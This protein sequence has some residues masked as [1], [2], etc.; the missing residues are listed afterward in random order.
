[1]VPALVAL[2]L[3]SPHI[4]ANLP[5]MKVA[6]PIRAQEPAP[7]D[8]GAQLTASTGGAVSCLRV[9]ALTR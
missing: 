4:V 2:V 6:Q 9:D 8:L 7:D 1:M 3:I 5:V